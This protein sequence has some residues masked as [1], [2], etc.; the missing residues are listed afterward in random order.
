LHYLYTYQPGMADAFTAINA[1]PPE[2]APLVPES[3]L[4]LLP[5][6]HRE[7]FAYLVVPLVETLSA[8]LVPDACA[9]QPKRCE[10]VF[11]REPH[12]LTLNVFELNQETALL[13]DLCQEGHALATIIAL[14]EQQLR[15]TGL[16]DDILAMVG[17][18][19]AQQIIGIRSEP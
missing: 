1:E 17:A 18:L 4:V 8:N 3:V 6:V 11:Q 15:E 19:Q 13:L 12:S 2:A 7:V 10:L 16:G 5:D 14:V 9:S